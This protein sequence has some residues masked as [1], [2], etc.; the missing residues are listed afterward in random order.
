M[1]PRDL[2]LGKDLTVQ[3]SLKDLT[4]KFNNVHGHRNEA[5]SYHKGDNSPLSFLKERMIF[6]LR[7]SSSQTL[8]SF[9]YK[10]PS[11]LPLF[12]FPFSSF[13]HHFCIAS[14][15]LSQFNCSTRTFSHLITS[16]FQ[17]LLPAT[18]FY[19]RSHNHTGTYRLLPGYLFNCCHFF[20]S[21]SA[22]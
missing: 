1:T 11:P 10:Y 7:L 18:A 2:N 22:C 12:P 15:V 3:P 13:H 20:I 14:P 21:S 5:L 9:V 17:T 4:F 8:L 16:I 19:S 6:P